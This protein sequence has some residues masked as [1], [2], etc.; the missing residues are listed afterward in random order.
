MNLGLTTRRAVGMAL[1]LSLLLVLAC[2]SSDEPAAPAAPAA[3]TATPTAPSVAPAFILPTATPVPAAPLPGVTAV[4]KPKPTSTPT[5]VPAPGEKPLYGGVTNLPMTGANRW[6]PLHG[7]QGFGW[8][9]IANIGNLFGQYIRADLTDRL[10]L[11]GDLAESWEIKDGGKTW[12]LK[13][14]TSYLMTS[15]VKSVFSSNQKRGLWPR[16]WFSRFYL[17]QSP[18]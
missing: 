13:T 4:A 8:G 12:V 10:T 9:T 5:P 7:N 6:D 16:F 11:E 2:G 17:F 18:Y 15:V 1:G 14:K 3:P